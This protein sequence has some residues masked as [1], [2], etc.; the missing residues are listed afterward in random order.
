MDAGRLI[1]PLSVA[2]RTDTSEMVATVSWAGE[3]SCHVARADL[4][5]ERGHPVADGGGGGEL[6]AVVAERRLDQHDGQPRRRHLR[7]LQ[8]V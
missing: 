1:D 2:R 6:E 8:L 4:G 5:G 3:W 7:F